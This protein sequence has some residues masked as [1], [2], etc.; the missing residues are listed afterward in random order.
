MVFSV[1]AKELKDTV[2]WLN[3][4]TKMN[5]TFIEIKAGWS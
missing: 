2:F 4:D 1:P 3:I 5:K